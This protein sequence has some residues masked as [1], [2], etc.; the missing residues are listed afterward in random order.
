M[1]LNLSVFLGKISGLVQNSARSK[2][3]FLLPVKDYVL[4]LQPLSLVASCLH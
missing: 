2:P 1:M 4:L 3:H